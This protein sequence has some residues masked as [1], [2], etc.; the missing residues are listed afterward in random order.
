MKF[1]LKEKRKRKLSEGQTVISL[2]KNLFLH[3][4]QEVR[5]N[6]SFSL[7]K[8]VWTLQL[9]KSLTGKH[10][11]CLRSNTEMTNT[12]LSMG[13]LRVSSLVFPYPKLK[14]LQEA[15]L[16]HNGSQWLSQASLGGIPK[17]ICSA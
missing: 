15:I 3:T 9:H 13:L 1:K 16:L 6:I 12:S 2:L 11:G 14:L 8:K 7:G 4:L 10:T 17:L 5:V